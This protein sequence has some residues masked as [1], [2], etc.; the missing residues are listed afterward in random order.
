MLHRLFPVELL[1]QARFRRY[2]PVTLIR[3]FSIYFT[4][5]PSLLFEV[6]KSFGWLGCAAFV[7]RFD[8]QMSSESSFG[9][10]VICK[11]L[12]LALYSRS[13]DPLRYNICAVWLFYDTQGMVDEGSG[14]QSC[15]YMISCR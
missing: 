9:A 7:L 15:Q 13:S 4:R 11:K 3:S 6:H 8:F 12:R 2:D 5:V 1:A 10:G 14:F